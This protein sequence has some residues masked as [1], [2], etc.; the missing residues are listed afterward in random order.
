[1]DKLAALIQTLQISR[2]QPHFNEDADFHVMKAADRFVL[3][4]G[5][6]PS[7]PVAASIVLRGRG[8]VAPLMASVGCFEMHIPNDHALHPLVALF[9]GEISAPRCGQD[10]LLAGYA[11]VLIVHFLRAALETGTVDKGVWAALSDARLSR[12]L[13]Q[14]HLRP[15]HAWS[16]E[17]L[18]QEAGMSRS[19]FMA[20]FRE[21][22]GEAPI[23]YLRSFRIARAREAL[24]EGGRIAVVARTFGYSSSDAFSRAFRRSQG[25]APSEL[26]R[27]P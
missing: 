22:M 17:D 9:V 11:Q 16:T 3:K 12:A 14:V 8:A 25:I 7:L 13:T 5:A 26:R 18:A 6:N 23:T 27:G 1:M 21:V 10:S 15:G 19:V 4:S 20:Q 2:V 24:E